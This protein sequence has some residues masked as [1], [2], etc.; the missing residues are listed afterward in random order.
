MQN[1]KKNRFLFGR[2][3]IIVHLSSAMTAL[4]VCIL[5][6]LYTSSAA[7]QHTGSSFNF[8]FNCSPLFPIFSF[9]FFFVAKIALLFREGNE[10]EP[11]RKLFHKIEHSLPMLGILKRNIGIRHILL[12]CTCRVLSADYKSL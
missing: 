2:F 8:C 5:V 12:L 6:Y 4:Y 10:S 1:R 3:I 7:L 9:S 11:K